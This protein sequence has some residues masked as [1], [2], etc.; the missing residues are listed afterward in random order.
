LFWN[1][2]LFAEAG[3]SGPPETLDEMVEFAKKLTKKDANGNYLT[4]GF[5]VD[6]DGQDHHWWREVLIRLYGGQPYSDDGKSVA[7]TSEAGAK[8]LKFI[9]D[10][11]ATHKTGSNGFHEPWSRCV[12]CWSS[13]YG[14]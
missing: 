8:A 12:C 13:W 5:A 1:K 2:D 4:V 9:T 7:Y 6:T 11:E 14:S 3:L 10:F